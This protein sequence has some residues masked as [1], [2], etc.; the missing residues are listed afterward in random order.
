M[1]TQIFLTKLLKRWHLVFFLCPKTKWKSSEWFGET[2]PQPKK[3]KFQKS[4]IK[5][6]LIIFFDYQGVGHKEFIPQGNTVNA[7]F[8]KGV[9]D[10]H[11]KRIQ[12]VCPAAFCSQ[13]FFLLYNNAPSHKPVSVC[14]FF[15][16]Q[17][18]LQPSIIPHT[19]Q[20]YL[21]QTI[22]CS[23]SWKWS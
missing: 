22:F 1:Q 14:Q 12:R 7:E 5:N 13:D 18:M 23:P 9:M 16:P 10:R 20:I 6:I 4:C 21:R 19:L 17:K 8:Y 15:R 11:L 3:L 2:S